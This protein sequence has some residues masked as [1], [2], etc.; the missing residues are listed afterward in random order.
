M[1]ILFVDLKKAYDSVPRLALWSVL[2]KCGVP[3]RMLGIIRSFHD[4]MVAR[5][6]VGDHRTDDIVVNNGLRQGCVLAPTLFNIYFSAV[7]GIGPRKPV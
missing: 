1:I 6:R 4:G 2:E 3:P 5:V 7:G